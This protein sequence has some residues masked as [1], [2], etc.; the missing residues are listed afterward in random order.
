MFSLG[1]SSR[2]K[3]VI[4]CYCK[5]KQNFFKITTIIGIVYKAFCFSVAQSCL[6]LCNPMDY[7]TPGFSVLQ[8]L[9]ELAQ[10]HVH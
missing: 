4:C 5:L 2:K 10:T 8:H 1:N 9:S 6:T 3:K 7:S